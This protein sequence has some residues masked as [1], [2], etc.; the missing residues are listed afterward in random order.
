MA[1]MR[2]VWGCSRWRFP[3]YLTSL[4]SVLAVP[5]L[6][7]TMRFCDHD[8]CALLVHGCSAAAANAYGD[9]LMHRQLVLPLLACHQ[10]YMHQPIGVLPMHQ[11][12]CL[13]N[14]ASITGESFTQQEACVNCTSCR[15]GECSPETHRCRVAAT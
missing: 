8:K 12:G 6:Y 11:E 2:C 15:G 7:C 5:P 10:A 13:Y 9:G 4:A 14:K 1:Q 3:G